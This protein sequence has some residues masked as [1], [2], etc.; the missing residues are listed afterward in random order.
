MEYYLCDLLRKPYDPVIVIDASVTGGLNHLES[1]TRQNLMTE[2]NKRRRIP[3]DFA[4]PACDI[5]SSTHHKENYPASLFKV[6]KHKTLYVVETEL[7]DTEYEDSLEELEE[8]GLIDENI[9]NVIRTCIDEQLPHGSIAALYL[10]MSY[11]AY[12][13]TDKVTLISRVTP[14]MN[15]VRNSLETNGFGG[16]RLNTPAHFIKKMSW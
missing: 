10:A 4:I 5:R 6:F 14:R 16:L 15:S 1:P 2:I 7:C 12:R 13:E 9:D 8:A 3:F 11:C